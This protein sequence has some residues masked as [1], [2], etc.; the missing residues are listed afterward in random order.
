[1]LSNEL[2]YSNEAE[3]I[4]E[5]LEF[6]ERQITPETYYRIEHRPDNSLAI[7]V[8]ACP[9][10]FDLAEGQVIEADVLHW[11][12]TSKSHL[13]KRPKFCRSFVWQCLIDALHAT[14]KRQ[15]ADLAE[16]EKWAADIAKHT[17]WAREFYE[18]GL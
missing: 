5:W 7:I 12:V 11:Q 16:Y 4:V 3:I 10:G 2:T 17:R 1:M 15:P 6:A 9:Q 14:A 18:I 13:K 8:G